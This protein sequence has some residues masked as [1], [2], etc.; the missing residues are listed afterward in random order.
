MRV[1]LISFIF[2]FVTSE[3]A[4]SQD[5]LTQLKQAWETLKTKIQK[6]AEAGDAFLSVLN[7]LK[8]SD[9]ASLDGFRASVS[10]LRDYLTTSKFDSLTVATA[11]N[12]HAAFKEVFYTLFGSIDTTLRQNEELQDRRGDL[13]SAENQLFVATKAYNNLCCW[14]SDRLCVSRRCC[15]TKT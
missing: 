8:S 2:L 10:H 12:K 4:V 13:L 5:S 9:S 7:K 15:M 6:R 3:E 14:C 11:W 1:I